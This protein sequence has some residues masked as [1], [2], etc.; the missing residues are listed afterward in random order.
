MLVWID[1]VLR[2]NTQQYH[3]VAGRP[4]WVVLHLVSRLS[5][6]SSRFS[7]SLISISFLTPS[8]ASNSKGNTVLSF[9]FSFSLFLFLLFSHLSS[10]F[11]SLSHWLHHPSFSLLFSPSHIPHLHPLNLLYL[12]RIVESLSSLLF[13][14]VSSPE[15][16][17]GSVSRS[18]S[19]FSRSSRSLFLLH[20]L[21]SISHLITVHDYSNTKDNLISQEHVNESIHQHTAQQPLFSLSLSLPNLTTQLQDPKRRLVIFFIFSCVCLLCACVCVCICACMCAD[22][23]NTVKLCCPILHSVP[24]NIPSFHPHTYTYTLQRY[25]RTCW[26]THISMLVFPPVHPSFLS[27]H[28]SFL[29]S[30]QACTKCTTI[31]IHT[32]HTQRGSWNMIR[33]VLEHAIKPKQQLAALRVDLLTS[34]V[35]G[36]NQRTKKSG[37]WSNSPIW[38]S[39]LWPVMGTIYWEMRKKKKWVIKTNMGIG[40]NEGRVARVPIGSSIVGGCFVYLSLSHLDTCYSS[41]S[42]TSVDYF[43]DP[44]CCPRSCVILLSCRCLCHFCPQF[45][46]RSK[47]SMRRCAQ[48]VFLLTKVNS[49]VLA[50][51]FVTLTVC[52]GVSL[53]H[54]LLSTA[55]AQITP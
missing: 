4:E 32:L 49:F 53:F 17:L 33:G 30:M 14:S 46:L 54:G 38:T 25:T 20:P 18:N 37:W 15:C 48:K 51:S 34:Q 35:I 10:S 9:F 12:F 40:R 47:R 19:I 27:L 41:L 26:C 7:F 55:V 1:I 45:S 23:A 11:F 5:F 31:N 13:C 36:V 21:P 44:W 6:H 42:L 8:S 3:T 28:P 22:A 24:H 29:P 2:V 16:R 52:L 39:A 43:V 50:L